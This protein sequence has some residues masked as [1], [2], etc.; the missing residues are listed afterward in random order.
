MGGASTMLAFLKR[1]NETHAQSF[2]LHHIELQPKVPKAGPI[3][4]LAMFWT[5]VSSWRNLLVQ[6]IHI[7]AVLPSLFKFNCASPLDV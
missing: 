2:F 3:V 6:I 5:L 4:P 1:E 7:C